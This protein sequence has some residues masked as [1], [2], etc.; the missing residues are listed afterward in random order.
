MKKIFYTLL[1]VCPFL[2]ITSCEKKVEGCTDV[3]AVNYDSLATD[4]NSSC[5]YSIN[6]NWDIVD[7]ITDGVSQFDPSIEDGYVM[8]GG[9]T[10]NDDGSCVIVTQHS[11]Y[12]FGIENATWILI[13]TNQLIITYQDTDDDTYSQAFTITELNAT[14]CVVSIYDAEFETS[15]FIFLSR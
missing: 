5:E 4:D 15:S 11:S 3:L 14:S 2:F 12:G 1:L 7:I 10:F 13:G 8:S 6:G 9:W